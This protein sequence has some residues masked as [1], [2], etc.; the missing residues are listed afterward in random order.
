[1]AGKLTNEAPMSK[2]QSSTCP[3]C[4][5]AGR[6]DFTGRDLMFGGDTTY[7]YHQCTSC[8][9]VYQTPMPSHEQITGFY[10]DNYTV[11][12]ENIKLKP[13]DA[14]ERAMLN[15]SYGYKHLQA[16]AALKLLTPL[17]APFRDRN[18]LPYEHGGRMLDIGCANGRFMLR[19]QQLGWQ[20]QGVEFNQTAVDI[21]G[22]NNLDVFHGELEDAGL[23]ENTFDLITARHVIE[24][25]PNPDAFI[26]DIARLLK[27]GGRMHLRTPS[28]EALGRRIFGEFWYANDAPRHL[29]LFSKQNLNMLA[30]RHGLEPV[31]LRTNVRPKLVLNSL[32][33]KNRNTGKPSRRSKLRRLLAKLY[34]PLAKPGGRGDELFAV[35]RKP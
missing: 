4:R 32:D 21:C 7:E 22:R 18:S 33:Y 31:T 13:R 26:A 27:P 34:V 12:D 29:F 6:H 11:Y 35:Y 8:G 5:G 2:T 16:P 25:V 15:V 19:M 1:M 14:L 30:A 24:H 3:L 10:P 23:E 20:V 28:S 17:L 9:A